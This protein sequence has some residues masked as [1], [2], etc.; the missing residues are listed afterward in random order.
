MSLQERP[1]DPSV[2][3]KRDELN[4]RSEAILKCR[5]LT[6]EQ[7]QEE[8][9]AASRYVRRWAYENKIHDWREVLDALGLA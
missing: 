1:T 6:D 2:G 7:R 8:N 3:P 5:D 9:A 4:Q